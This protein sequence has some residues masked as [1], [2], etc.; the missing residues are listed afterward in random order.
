MKDSEQAIVSAGHN[1]L[2]RK[3]QVNASQ[4]GFSKQR[5]NQ[6]LENKPLVNSGVP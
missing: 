1:R 3:D 2:L 4:I 5:M 6:L